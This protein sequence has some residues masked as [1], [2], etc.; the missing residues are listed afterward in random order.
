M[1]MLF[2]SSSHTKNCSHTPKPRVHNNNQFEII[3]PFDSELGLHRG[4]AILEC[5]KK[6]QILEQ[7]KNPGKMSPEHVND[8]IETS[9]TVG[10][11]VVNMGPK[12]SAR[13]AF[14]TKRWLCHCRWQIPHRSTGTHLHPSQNRRCEKIFCEFSQ[15]ADMAR[16]RRP[17]CFQRQRLQKVDDNH[18]LVIS[19]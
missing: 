14:R 13:A 12:D 19:F 9:K 16:T 1:S 11:T 15:A 10:V 18:N 3:C 5:R 2:L 7:G 6:F 17:E 4:T 8:M